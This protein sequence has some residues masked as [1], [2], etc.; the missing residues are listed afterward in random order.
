MSDRCER[1]PLAP[2]PSAPVLNVTVVLFDGGHPSRAVVPVEIF[3][4]AGQLWNKLQGQPVSHAFHVT[5][6]TV[7]GKFVQSTKG[8]AI[9]P[10]MSIDDIESTDI[11]VVPTSGLELDVKLVEN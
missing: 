8:L 3:H 2:R 4:A 7:D 10:E 11:I 5:T 1:L 6:V 9:T